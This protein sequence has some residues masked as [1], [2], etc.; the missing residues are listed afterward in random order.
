[1]SKKKIS[2]KISDDFSLSNIPIEMK[3]TDGANKI[4]NLE[5]YISVN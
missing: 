4:W 5:F 2:F 1:M 3:I